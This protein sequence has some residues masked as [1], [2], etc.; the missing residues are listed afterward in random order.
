MTI[1]CSAFFVAKKETRFNMKIAIVNLACNTTLTLILAKV[2]GL[3]GVVLGTS[4][5]YSLTLLLYIHGIRRRADKFSDRR[6]VTQVL[7]GCLCLSLGISVG[8]LL[9]AL[10]GDEPSLVAM[11]LI[12][13]ASAGAYIA[14]VL[15]IGR[16]PRSV[17][18]ILSGRPFLLRM[19]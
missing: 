12:A 18:E 2:M 7:L 16:T 8:T 13:G 17:I 4:L 5:T 3:Q 15:A 11:A 9:V 10:L 14:P 1:G 6:L 19:P